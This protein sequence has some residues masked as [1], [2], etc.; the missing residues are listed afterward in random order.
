M[1][2]WSNIWG[3]GSKA[4]L[5]PIFTAQKKAIWAVENGFVNFFFDKETGA[6][7]CHTKHIFK[8]NEFLTVHNLVAKNC[9][10]AMH[11]IHMDTYPANITN[12]FEVNGDQRSRRHVEIFKVPRF[13]T[14]KPD[15]SL[16][17]VGPKLYNYACNVINRE[18]E[19]HEIKLENKFL[20][21]FKNKIST[22]LLRL[23]SEGDEN[24]NDGNFILYNM[25]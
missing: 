25:Q 12:L 8:R 16:L 15:A 21:S 9:L 24:W 6:L 3:L 4:S 23:Q 20:N 17:N 19:F 11:R 18:L 2:Y 10:V 14:K 7:P 13:R 1:N 5:K 22:H